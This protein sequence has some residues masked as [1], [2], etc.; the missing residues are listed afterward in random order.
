MAEGYASELDEWRAIV[1]RDQDV[2]LRWLAPREGPLRYSLRKFAHV[3]DV[4]LIVQESAA[5][6]WHNAHLITPDGRPGFLLRWVRRV[7]R[8]DAI[9]AV[10]RAGR[11][12]RF[13]DDR[14]IADSEG[15][16]M[17]DLFLRARI[18]RCFGRLAA[19]ARRALRARLQDGGGRAD[20]DVAASIEMSFDAF[21]QNLARSRQALVKCLGSSGIDI[22][23]YL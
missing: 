23:E 16:R 6:V 10:K 11:Q 7:A 14:E 15:Q 21:R 3:V 22:T 12:D 2:F 18:Q 1:D 8:N 19:T 5:K 13:D 17:P 4:E 20:R 9:N